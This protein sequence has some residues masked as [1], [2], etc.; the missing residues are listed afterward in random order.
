M[1]WLWHLVQQN[2]THAHSYPD[3]CWGTGLRTPAVRQCA[4]SPGATRCNPLQPAA[5]RV[6]HVWSA[7]INMHQHTLTYININKPIHK[8]T[9]PSRIISNVSEHS[10]LAYGKLLPGSN[11]FLAPWVLA[12]HVMPWAR[13]CWSWGL[14]GNRGAALS[15][16]LEDWVAVHF[17][18]NWAKGSLVRLPK[19]KFM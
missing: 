12:I 17:L 6:F 18:T 16:L 3:C 1:I 19:G 14:H 4:E 9:L 15:L 5:T 10:I 13:N 7:D 11:C 2:C 8:H